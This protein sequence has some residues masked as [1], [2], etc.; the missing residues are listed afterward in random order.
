[1]LASLVLVLPLAGRCAAADPPEERVKVTV[2]AILANGSGKV[3]DRLTCVARQVH[4]LHPRLTGFQLGTTTTR[5]MA[6][7]SAET[8]R[9]ADGQVATIAVKRCTERAGS[10]CLDIKSKALVGEMTYS[11]VCGKYFPLVTEYKTKKDGDQLI[12]AFM[13]ESCAKKDKGKK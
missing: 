3:D 7:G 6:L 10:F 12:I 5:T 8:F 4:E 11:S 2:A 13:V 1:V 9:L